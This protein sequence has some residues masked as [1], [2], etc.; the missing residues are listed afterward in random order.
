MWCERTGSA[1][2]EANPIVNGTKK[3]VLQQDTRDVQTYPYCP[4]HRGDS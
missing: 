1:E 3:L 4:D 2:K